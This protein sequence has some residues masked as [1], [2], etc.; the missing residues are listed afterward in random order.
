MHSITIINYGMGNLW[1]V[2]TAIEYLGFKTNITSSAIEIVNSDVLI[3][4]GVGSFKLAM[5]KIHA[6]NL[7]KAILEAVEVK[8]KKI[9]G[10]CLG[11]QLM[12]QSGTE[13][14]Y[15]KGLSLINAKTKKFNNNKINKFKIPHIGFNSVFKPTK[16]ILYSGLED[17]AD[18]YFVHSYYLPIKEINA[19]IGICNYSC[20]FMASYEKENIFATQFH[21]EKSQT[22]G[23]KL[24]QNFLKF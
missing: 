22:N 8:Q 24:L 6:L 19:N 5:N 20:N 17:N 2:K 14:G 3:L 21:P 13:D 12:S 11:I 18:F 16:S 10:I 9:L 15:S 7:D 4:P 1:S 23:L